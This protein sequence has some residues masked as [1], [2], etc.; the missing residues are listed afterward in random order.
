MAPS[1][2]IELGHHEEVL[3]TSLK[4]TLRLSNGRIPSKTESAPA[5]ALKKSDYQVDRNLHKAFP[6][7]KGGKGNYLYLADGRKIFDATSGAAVSCLGYDN[8]RV[9]NAISA[10]MHSGIS[11]LASSFWA[12]AIVEELAEELISGTDGKM[13]RVYLTGSGKTGT[14]IISSCLTKISRVRSHGGC[15]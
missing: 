4:T 14:E 12:S 10:Q 6:V 1:A 11:Y 7:V 2:V 15:N 13:T 3:S 5:A 9:I 8:K